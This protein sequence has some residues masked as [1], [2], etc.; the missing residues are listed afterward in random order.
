MYIGPLGRPA[1]LAD[2]ALKNKFILSIVPAVF[3][4]RLT[5]IV[6][7]DQKGQIA[8]TVY[9]VTKQ[10]AGFTEWVYQRL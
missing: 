6:M 8:T 3:R 5:T 7:P 9:E 4:R 1:K 2:G 10:I